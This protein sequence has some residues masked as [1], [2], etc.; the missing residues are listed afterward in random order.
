LGTAEFIESWRTVRDLSLKKQKPQSAEK[1]ECG[2]V[3][4]NLSSLKSPTL[5]VKRATTRGADGGGEN[6]LHVVN[7]AGDRDRVKPGPVWWR[8]KLWCELGRALMIWGIGEEAKSDSSITTPRG[9]S[10]WGPVRSE[11][12][13]GG[14]RSGGALPWRG[15]EAQVRASL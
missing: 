7:I 13:G 11:C 6:K 12:F 9:K 14:H 1:A 5:P 4:I 15:S 8:V 10:V 3:V 2:C